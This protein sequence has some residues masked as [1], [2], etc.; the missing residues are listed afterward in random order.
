MEK[1]DGDDGLLRNSRGQAAKGGNHFYVWL[2]QGNSVAYF[3]YRSLRFFKT[4]FN[5]FRWSNWFLILFVRVVVI[6]PH[7][8]GF[9]DI[10]LNFTLR[11]SGLNFVELSCI[12]FSQFTKMP[13]GALVNLASIHHD[14]DII[15]RGRGNFG[16]G[17]T[18]LLK[19]F[20][21]LNKF[22]WMRFQT[23]F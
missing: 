5:L 7:F 1:L 8:D 11:D 16:R 20:T 13:L 15:F 3:E 9:R 23:N 22:C 4:S 10:L 21:F 19:N 2:L 6:F 14:V 17:T 12:Y 18:T